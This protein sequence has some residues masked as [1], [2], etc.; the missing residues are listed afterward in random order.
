MQ[1]VQQEPEDP[2]LIGGGLGVI[3]IVGQILPVGEEL[4]AQVFQLLIR[5]FSC[6]KVTNRPSQRDGV[7]G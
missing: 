6:Q 2:L 5:D 4:P 1:A 7:L 3:G